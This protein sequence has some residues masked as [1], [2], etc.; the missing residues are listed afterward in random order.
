MKPS[1]FAPNLLKD[2]LTMKRCFYLLTFFVITLFF[3]PRSWAQTG[4]NSSGTDFWLQFMPNGAGNGNTDVYEDLFVASGTDNKVTFSGGVAT[5]TITMTAGSVYDYFCPNVM[6]STDEV[7]QPDAIHVTSQNPVVIYGYST[8]GNVQGQGDSPDGFLALPTTAYGTEYYTVNFPDNYVFGNMP[9]EFLITSP[10]D[11]NQITITPA[12]VTKGGKPANVPFNITLQKGETYL[13]QSPGTD[14]GNNDLTGTLIVSSKP[15]SVLTGHQISSVPTDC[16]CSS[17]DNLFE[18]IPSVDRWGTEYFDEPMAG[19]TIAG[20]YL[21]VLSA[22]NGNQITYNGNGPLILDSGQYSD[23]LQNTIPMVLKSINHKRFIV[24]QY[25]YSQGM[26]GDPGYSD[27]W[28]VLFTPQEQFE[29]EMIFRTPTSTRGAF[30]NYLTIISREDSISKITINGLPIGTFPQVGNAVFAGTN[31]Q[32][33]ARR[34]LL[35]AQPQNYIAKGPE[36]FGMYQYG[37]SDY[38]G[39]GWPTGMA[40]RLIS[41]D[42]LPPLAQT[43]DSNCGDYAVR[44]TEPRIK[45]NGYSFNDTHIASISMITAA[46]DPRWPTPSY[47]YTFTPDPNFQVADSVYNG[48]LTVNDPTKDAYAAIFAVD[49]AGND[50][51][52]QYYYYAPKVAFTPTSPY[53]FGTILDGTDSCRT[54]T[55]TNIQSGGEFKAEFDSIGGFAKGGNFDVTP[56]TLSPIDSGR[57]ITLN[58]CFHATDTGVQSLDSLYV[59]AKC[60]NYVFPVTGSAV[61]PLIYAN[62]LAFGEVD[63]GKTRCK[64]L[65]IQNPGKWPLT[66][67]R[68]D[69]TNDPNFSV[70][71]NQTFPIV[72]PPNGTVQ[73]LY[74][75][76]PQ[77]WGSFSKRVTFFNLNPTEFQHSI[78]DTALLTGI[79]TPAG[80]QLTSYLKT[81]T[82][83][84]NDTTVNDTV[85]NNLLANKTIDSIVLVG[86]DA[87][88]FTLTDNTVYPFTLK[89]D[90]GNTIPFQVT[91]HPTLNGLDLTP[92]QVVVQV[93]AAP[94]NGPQPALTIHAQLVTPIVQLSSTSVNLGTT[95]INEITK[96]KTFE[97]RNTGNAPLTI[98]S[99]TVG[100]ANPGLFTFAPT[101]PDTIAPGDSQTV[102]VTA[103]SATE[104]SF[105]ATFGSGTDAPCNSVTGTVTFK[106][107][108]VGATSQ[109]TVHPVTYTGGCRSNTQNAF[110]ANLSTSD[111]IT[112][113]NVAI[114]NANGFN[115]ALDFS[116]TNSYQNYKV[117]P[118]DTLFVPVQFQPLATGPRMAA[119]IFTVTG[120][121]ANGTIGTWSDTDTVSG[122]GAAVSREIGVGS[123]TVLQQYHAQPNGGISIPIVVN[124]PIDMN[125]PTNGTTEAYGYQF[126]V[127]WRRDAFEFVSSSAATVDAPTYNTTTDMETRHVH[128]ESSTPLTNVSTLV[129]LN[130]KAMVSKTDT[131]G[132]QISNVSWLGKDTIPLCYVTDT[133][134]NGSQVLDPVCGTNTLQTYM[135][136]GGISIDGIHPNPASTSTQVDYRLATGRFITIAVYDELGDPVKQLLSMDAE[137]SGAHSLQFS[138]DNLPSGTYFCRITDGHFVMTQQFQVAK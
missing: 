107:N 79:A 88:Y 138:T 4:V 45:E 129:T 130:F 135:N 8:W 53:D 82:V 72:I 67:T 57:S 48:M 112:V 93:H 114:A 47:N 102:T 110:F 101:L 1:A 56:T 54:I 124:T 25:S 128:F 87:S 91:F 113:D 2:F 55:I 60:V 73:V 43:L 117:G 21:R 68:Q 36:P 26:F 109:G 76:H 69:L 96:P 20:D 90:T 131:T 119:I 63:S 99:Y 62:D 98:T 27:P 115:D 86:P 40:Q 127:S 24:A 137:T 122:I 116:L 80:A 105:S 17:A 95:L 38:E 65:T 34:I 59:T 31:P 71:P 49:L 134:L 42:T 103:V 44:Y 108:S 51:I 136:L 118:Q 106:A 29:T 97:I 15:I 133:L 46:N 9:G 37:F 70:D 77:S 94:E 83:S 3:T 111:T 10:Y 19:K 30:T 84:C 66:I 33:G 123:P 125:A 61:T 14:F 89:G 11:G 75:F 104:G 41:P 5:K 7:P 58:V 132:I 126:D 35:A 50:T 39:Y 28:M 78:K 22:E 6:N 100:G 13:V 64:Q 74:C 92:R 16:G 85:F 32:M 120:K 18:M 23:I 12:A 81:F 121:Q 52:Y